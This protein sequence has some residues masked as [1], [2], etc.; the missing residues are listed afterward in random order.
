ML[1]SLLGRPANP[2]VF[3]ARGDEPAVRRHRLRAELDAIVAWLQRLDTRIC[4][5]IAENSADWIR[6]DLACQLAN[7]VLV[8][9]PHFFSD[10]QLANCIRR[11]GIDLV[12][13]DRAGIAKL[14]GLGLTSSLADAPPATALAAGWVV[15]PALARLP[16]GTAKITFTSGSTGEPKGVCLSVAHQW[17][18][19]RSITEVLDV[20]TSRHLALLPLSTLLENIA[21]VYAPLLRDGVLLVP[22]DDARGVS[23][24]S[25]LD[26]QALLSCLER[27]RPQSLI[28]IPQLLSVLV[29]ACMQGWQPPATLECIAV[30]G[31]RVA[32]TLLEA[33]A[34]FGLPVYE[35]YGLSECAS[36]VSLNTPARR[37]VGTV[38]RALPHCQV[39]VQAGELTVSGSPHLGYLGDEDSWYPTEVR[40]GDLCTLDDGWLAI[41]GRRGNLLIT[42]Y[43]RNV[44][45]E[46]VESTITANPLI[47]QCV[48]LGEARPYLT[49]F[50]GAS[51]SVTG[52]AI[53][54]WLD[55]ANT[56]LPDYA[57]VGAWR[58]LP[59]SQWAEFTTSN[60]RPRRALI[61]QRLGA[62]IDAMYDGTTAAR[63]AS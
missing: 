15:K 35:G 29:A 18:V 40:T 2:V 6:I 28:L 26:V 41:G 30:G 22:G 39:R 31:A 20:V 10:D 17:Q 53:Q 59:Q 56:R 23:G 32:D 63:A 58:R 51:E 25:K 5:L 44:H 43:G 12:I 62:A 38:G 1:R 9:L 47:T 60:G 50:M 3:A 36:V 4:G 24:S 54:A 13:G 61:A 49:A 27:E 37:R 19:A 42:S 48:V 33:A 52:A 21:G 7:K 45:P 14:G 34:G 8:P 11:A 16:R 57:R 55:C 46:W